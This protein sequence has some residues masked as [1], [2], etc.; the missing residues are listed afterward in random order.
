MDFV[1]CPTQSIQ[2]SRPANGQVASGAWQLDPTS[3][4]GRFSQE[5]DD[6]QVLSQD[7][8]RVICR[9]WRPG[10]DGSRRPVLV[11]M[12]AAEPPSPTS[13]EHLAHEY[14]LK[15]ELDGAWAVRPLELVHDR[16]RTMLVL[17]DWAASRWT[18]CLAR[19]WRWDTS[20]A[21]Q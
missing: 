1:R 4:S 21:W 12:A 14:E 10:A 2:S 13:L 7:G 20:C 15:D 6:L 9:G 5:E 19:P 18:D 8:E 3:R 17:E 11:V 16:G